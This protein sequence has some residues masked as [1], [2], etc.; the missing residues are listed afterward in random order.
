MWASL[1][2]HT[3]RAVE[4]YAEVL[5]SLAHM[6]RAPL[7]PGAA[8]TDRLRQRAGYKKSGPGPRAKGSSKDPGPESL[9]CVG[10]RLLYMVTLRAPR[11]RAAVV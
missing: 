10:H 6:S 1:L 11:F 4:I 9:R 2:V 8:E 7:G 3:Y 5:R